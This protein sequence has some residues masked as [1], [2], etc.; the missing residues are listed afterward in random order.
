MIVFM[1]YA[2]EDVVKVKPFYDCLKKAGYTPWMD[3]YD[4]S[5]GQ[6]WKFAIQAAIS[7]CD[8]AIIFLSS[9]SVTKTGYVQV[10]LRE[11]FDQQKRRPVG[12]IYLI[13]VRLDDCIVPANITDLHYADLFKEDGW[14]NVMR[15]L[16]KAE[17]HRSL[18][19]E[20]GEKLASFTVFT[21]VLEEHWKG[22]PGYSARLSYPELLGGPTAEACQELNTLFKARCLSILQALRSGRHQQN[23]SFFNGANQDFAANKVILDYKICCCT[24]AVVSVVFTHYFYGAGAAHGNW[25]FITDNF[26]LEPVTRLSLKTFFEGDRNYQQVLQIKARELLKREA[27]EREQTRSN[28]FFGS[29]FE[30][31]KWLC[32]GTDFT[33]MAK[34]NF[35]F[36]RQGFTLYF[37]PYEIACF[38]AGPWEVTLPYYD[39]REVLRSDGP[40][41]LVSQVPDRT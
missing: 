22:L 41:R 14:A 11:F 33:N 23:V 38:A 9:E 35:T 25:E 10:E 2:K 12:S 36:S 28:G 1:S 31:E 8:A 18:L 26:L 29:I 34:V 40:Q 37:S 5:P 4:I 39:L 3:H 32:S 17:H 24:D 6:D 21:R 19:R 15:S 27:W 30:D 13:P 16:E 20:Q 7:S